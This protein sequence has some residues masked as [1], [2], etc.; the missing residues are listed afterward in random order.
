MLRDSL[1]INLRHCL[2]VVP[3]ARLRTDEVRHPLFFAA[4]SMTTTKTTTTFT[5]TSVASTTPV[6]TTTTTPTPPTTGEAL[7]LR[8]A[9]RISR[10]PSNFG[11]PV[12]VRTVFLVSTRQFWVSGVVEGF[13]LGG[14]CSAQR[15]FLTH[16][17]CFSR[18]SKSELPRDQRSARLRRRTAGEDGTVLGAGADRQLWA[19]G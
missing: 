3:L 18:C 10:A 1:A 16:L 15:W 19:A 9:R 4:E 12:P 11:A 2:T 17:V 13:A 5:T 14:L 6:M 8:G 7:P